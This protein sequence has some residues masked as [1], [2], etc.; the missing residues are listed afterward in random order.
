MIEF[1]S[2]IEFKDF[3]DNSFIE[4]FGFKKF[5]DF[6][7]TTFFKNKDIQLVFDKTLN[8]FDLYQEMEDDL[9]ILFSLINPIVK[10]QFIVIMDC[11]NLLNNFI[12]NNEQK[13]KT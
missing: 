1:N 7:D 11:F 9:K 8:T 6:K 4:Q 10:Y 5:S 2:L 3:I 13:E 12:K